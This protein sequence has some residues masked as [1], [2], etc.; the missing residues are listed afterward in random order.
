MLQKSSGGTSTFL[1]SGLLDTFSDSQQKQFVLDCVL[2]IDR[3]S[4]QRRGHHPRAASLRPRAETA[5]FAFV[6]CILTNGP[7]SC[8]WCRWSNNSCG[9]AVAAQPSL[10]SKYWAL[11]EI[12]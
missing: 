8:C 5:S 3:S 7:K 12:I 6:S 11:L 9:A 10:A 4:R 2:F 1:P